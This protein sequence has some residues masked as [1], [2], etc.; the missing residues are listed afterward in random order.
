MKILFV[1]D[2]VGKP[3]RSAVQKLVPRLREQHGLD[4]CVGNS[5]NSAGGAG[6]TPDSADE[7]LEAGLDLL[8]SGN[9]TFSKREI[10]SYLER[11]GSRQLRPANYPDGAP[12]RGHAVIETRSGTRLGVINLEGRV[13]MKPLECPFRTADRLIEQMGAQGVRCILVDMHCE[14]T[15]EK[16]AM[17]HYLDGRVSAVLGSHTHIQTADERVL[18]GGTAYITDA[19]MCGPWDS[20]IGLRKENAIERFLT[21]RHAPF[22]LG[23]GD[24]YL[25]GAIV[26]IDEETGRAR[27]I[28]RVQERL[29]E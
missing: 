9:H 12:G 5:E 13:F 19:G 4:L 24:V 11:S 8:T 23:Q 20:V 10:A 1:G 17:G 7:L 26:G 15:S 3:G 18:G 16:N 28:L 29:P 25:Q 21:Q 27:S 2:I 6:I 22:D 14:A